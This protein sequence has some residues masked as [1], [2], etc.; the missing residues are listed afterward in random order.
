MQI[1]L[2]VSEAIISYRA[3]TDVWLPE[4]ERLDSIIDESRKHLR[5]CDEEYIIEWSKKI[6]NQRNSEAKDLGRRIIGKLTQGGKKL[7]L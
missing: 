7:R 3:Q 6:F 5:D 1:S 4:P 2:T